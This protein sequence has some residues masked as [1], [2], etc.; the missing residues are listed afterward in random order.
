[1]SPRKRKRIQKDSLRRQLGWGFLFGSFVGFGFFIAFGFLYLRESGYAVSLESLQMPTKISAIVAE[2]VKETETIIET[3]S[4]E[5]EIFTVHLPGIYRGRNEVAVQNREIE[6]TPTPFLPGDPTPTFAPPTVTATPTP[7]PIPPTPTLTPEVT[8]PAQAYIQDIYGIDPAMPLSCESSSAVDWA[9][10]FGVSLNEFTFFD[11]LPKSDNP[12]K[13]F[14]GSVY[15]TWG[16]I[17]PNPYGVH[18][19]PVAQLLREYGLP[20]KARR[21]MN[22]EALKEEI[23]AGQP[24]I[25]WVIGNVWYGGDG[26]TYTSSDGET[27]SVAG[28]QHTV[29]VIGYDQSTI[30]ILDGAMV[31][32]RPIDKFLSSWKTLGNQAVI[33]R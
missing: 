19:R 13:G 30:T 21:G 32:Q 23:A 1:M 2:E 7:T 33:Y 28:Y 26:I 6:V 17:P 22:F 11:Q 15:G 27:T 9:R 16:Q 14:V 24:V 25:V 20:A 3:S 18:A 8:L 12:E 31:Y 29:I 10:F 5:V 4:P